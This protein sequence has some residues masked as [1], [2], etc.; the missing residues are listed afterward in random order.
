MRGRAG[1]EGIWR[2][3]STPGDIRF[4]GSGV[5][6]PAGRGDEGKRQATVGIV[7]AERAGGPWSAQAGGMATHQRATLRRGQWRALG[8]SGSQVRVSCF[9]CYK[10]GAPLIQPL[11]HPPRAAPPGWRMSRPPPHSLLPL[12]MPPAHS[13]PQPA[14][15]PLPSQQWLRS[16]PFL[17]G[18]G[19]RPP[20]GSRAPRRGRRVR[21]R[22]P[23]P[24]GAT[25]PTA[26]RAGW[27]P[28]LH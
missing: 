1:E 25:Y 15:R 3:C 8:G 21:W 28:S 20:R 5:L 16:L 22:G 19:I 6:L 2:G 24:R 14:A 10:D 26:T 12:Q 18:R 13:L 27:P 11:L 4:R 23:R 7:R 17:L 9:G